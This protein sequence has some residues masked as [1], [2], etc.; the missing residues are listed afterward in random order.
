M[1]FIISKI[2]Y[3]YGNVCLFEGSISFEEEPETLVF[4][5]D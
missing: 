2:T 4:C 1:G 3:L 5:N